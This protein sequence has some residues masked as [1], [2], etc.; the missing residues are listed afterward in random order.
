MKISRRFDDHKHLFLVHV[1]TDSCAILHPHP[2]RRSFRDVPPTVIWR[3][4]FK[5]LNW[6]HSH[7]GCS[8]RA[9]LLDSWRV[10]I[11]S[12]KRAR[13]KEEG[14]EKG[15]K[16]IYHFRRLENSD[17]K[18]S[19]GRDT[20]GYRSVRRRRIASR[21]RALRAENHQPRYFVATGRRTRARTQ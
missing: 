16:A 14:N 9:H 3:P 15:L 11:L 7:A 8:E 5:V 12:I 4:R 2:V 10:I 6:M 20:G 21:A 13:E 18:T 17:A 1:I 19:A